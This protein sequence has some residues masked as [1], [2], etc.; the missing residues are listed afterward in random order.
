MADISVSVSIGMNLKVGI[1]IQDDIVLPIPGQMHRHIPGGP[2]K[3][4]LEV[5]PGSY[6]V[7]R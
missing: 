3:G 1:G 4:E 2:L 5:L 7:P 6:P